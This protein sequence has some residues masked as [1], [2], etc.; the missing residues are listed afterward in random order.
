MYVAD[1]NG[2]PLY[3]WRVLLL[4]FLEESPLASKI[5]ARRGVGFR[6]KL[7]YTKMQVP[8]FQCPSDPMTVPA[9]ANSCSYFAVVGPNAAW[10]G[11]TPRKLAE[12]KDPGET[13]MVVEVENSAASWAEPRRDLYVGQ[14]A[15]E[16]DPA[17]GQGLSSAAR[18]LGQRLIRRWLCRQPA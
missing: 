9:R 3:S 17:V 18:F 8:L 15:M 6:A 4:P 14:M 5:Q 1:A 10:A 13:I 12:F 7:P 16:L 11:T 2:N